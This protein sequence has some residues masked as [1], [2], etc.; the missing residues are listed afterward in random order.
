[1]TAPMPNH[2]AE[3][4][5]TAVA[6][7][8]AV[9]GALLIDNDCFERIGDLRAE[10]FTAGDHRAIFAEIARQ[11]AAGKA[12]DTITVFERLQATGQNAADLG[13]L[14]SLAQNTPGSASVGRHA[15]IIRERAI[16][17]A[18]L[19][20]GEELAD[21]AR[22]SAEEAPALIDQTTSR[23]EAIAQA[24]VRNEPTHV[25]D[26]LP[27]YVELLSDR[28]AG[29]T[30]AT[31]TGFPDVD[32]LLNGGFRAGELVVVAARP[33]M[34]KTAFALSVARHIAVKK[35][36]LILSMEMPTQ[37]LHDR[38]TAAIGRIQLQHLLEP[39]Q[40]LDDEWAR[41]THAIQ[42]MERMGLWID[43]QGALRLLDVRMKAKQVKRKA[44]LD[45]LVVDYLQLMEGDG[46]TRN[47]QI[48]TITR[49]LKA[50]AKELE[51][52]V[53]LLSQLNRELERRPN[54][55]PQPSDLRD[56]GAI[57]QDADVVMFLY[58]D[59]VYHADTMDKGIC[60]VDVALN[61]QGQS[62]R[63]ALSFIG[64]QTRF[65]AL[66]T[67]WHPSAAKRHP[68]PTRGFD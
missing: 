44:G 62:G 66:A 31:S 45:V 63:V 4:R 58:R 19:S 33:K 30:R 29:G 20:L 16:R 43:D 18:L 51:I 22:R 61:R 54:K 48:E 49:G 2:R 14:S 41:L 42:T 24:R 25:R 68:P 34:G 64:A 9:L 23:L 39:S 55:R 59:E 28:E 10:H 46:D 7:E 53:V 17:R 50:L 26:G 15:A 21:Q 5:L 57:E 40:M 32:T 67:A 47:A 6:S 13:Y 38:N 3:E 27:Q 12:A 56:S 11:I 37:Q 8:H 60:E 36:V 52:T 65:E 35:Q 1:M